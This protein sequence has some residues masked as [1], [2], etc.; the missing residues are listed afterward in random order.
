MQGLREQAKQEKENSLPGY[1]SNRGKRSGDL[2]QGDGSGD[3]EQTGSRCILKAE[4]I[5]FLYGYEF[6]KKENNRN[7]I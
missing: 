6:G 2:D 3:D 7:L 1:S 5:V 4:P